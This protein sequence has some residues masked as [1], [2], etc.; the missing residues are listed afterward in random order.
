MVAILRTKEYTHSE[1]V[2]LANR[3]LRNQRNCGLA[4]REMG[5]SNAEIPDCIGWNATWSHLIEVKT[6]RSDFLADKSK[7]WRQEPRKGMGMFRYYLAPTGI[8]EPE[9]LPERW[10]LLNPRGLSQ[11]KMIKE[12]MPF[13]EYDLKSELWITVAASRRIQAGCPYIAKQ[14]G[15]I[16]DF[17]RR[18]T[19]EA[20]PRNE[21]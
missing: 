12:P 20:M 10:G 5:G 9:E 14:L 18:A 17:E 6:S 3:W 7:P 8:I 2:L 19:T 15:I 1:L 16:T 4:V 11:I 21:E 13:D